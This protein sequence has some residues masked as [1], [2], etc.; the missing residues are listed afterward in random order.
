[1]WACGH[2]EAAA[3]ARVEIGVRVWGSGIGG[4]G[5]EA[6]SESIDEARRLS[7]RS[8][9]YLDASARLSVAV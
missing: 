7:A 1:M 3:G 2:L 8:V 6:E 5:L 4:R 9:G